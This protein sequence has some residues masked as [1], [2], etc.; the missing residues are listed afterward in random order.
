MWVSSV[1]ELDFFLPFLALMD[2]VVLGVK[3][4]VL[5][6]APFEVPADGV[7]DEGVGGGAIP[8]PVAAMSPVLW[9]GWCYRLRGRWP[10]GRRLS[11]K[12]FLPSSFC[13]KIGPILPGKP[14]SSI[15]RR[16]RAGCYRISGPGG[17][18]GWLGSL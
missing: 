16:F 8:R 5:G 11:P 14:I 1:T 17:C 12:R 9:W 7:D 6:R 18:P 2:L 13:Q 10:W 15:F 4:V 3:P